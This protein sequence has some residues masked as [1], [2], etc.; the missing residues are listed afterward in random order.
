MRGLKYQ[1]KNIRRDK[2]CI[3]SFLLPVI[4]GLV[5]SLLSGMSFSSAA[6]ISF[7]I[8][9]GELPGEAEEWLS[10]NGNTKEF[11]TRGSLDEAVNDPAT[12]MIGVLRDRNGIRTILAGDELQINTVI[13]DTLPRLFAQRD[14]AAS[15]SRSIIPRERGNEG[16]KSILIVITMVTAMFMG[17]TFNAMSMI[18][19]KEEGISFINELLPMTR[20]GYIIQKMVLGF[21]GGA[22]SA[23]VTALV[24]MRV[25]PSQMVQLVLIIVPSAFIAALT[26]LF[27]GHFSGSLMTGIV[28]IKAVM[29]IFLAPPILFYLVFPSDGVLHWL[30]CLF[31]SSAAFYGLMDLLNGQ[32]QNMWISFMI[33]MAHCFIWSF[34]FKIVHSN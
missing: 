17:C 34:V 7:G 11:E 9:N 31:P 26:G 16:I 12:Q 23:A 29:I 2:L 14:I 3:I 27:I 24:C 15:I 20:K 5:V 4:V 6:D 32:M 21:A 1:L 13:G 33:L 8:V 18:S 25:G 19:E 22:V 28:F 30:S 10:S